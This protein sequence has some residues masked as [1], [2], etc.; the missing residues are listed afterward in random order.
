MCFFMVTIRAHRSF[1]PFIL[2]SDDDGQVS[3]L[4]NYLFQDSI[5]G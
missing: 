5:L 1:L 4:D 2:P 3:V